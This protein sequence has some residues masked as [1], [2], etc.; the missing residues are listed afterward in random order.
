VMVLIFSS[1]TNP[2]QAGR[3][4]VGACRQQACPVVP[5][6]IEDAPPSGDLEYFLGSIQWFDA[7]EGPFDAHLARLSQ[8]LYSMLEEIGSP[9]RTRR[10]DTEDERLNPKLKSAC[11]TQRFQ[12]R[13]PVGRSQRSWWPWFAWLD[14]QD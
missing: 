7:F 12:R 13:V 2:V 10:D 4:R 14:S 3:T 11:S 1:R 6:R 9:D 5:F 8:T